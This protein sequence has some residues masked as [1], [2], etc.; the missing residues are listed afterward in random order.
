[1]VSIQLLIILV[2]I[3]LIFPHSWPRLFT[4]LSQIINFIS[5]SFLDVH[6]TSVNV[7]NFQ[8]SLS[9]NNNNLINEL[10]IQPF[11]TQK[12]I[13]LTNRDYL[14]KPS[15]DDQFTSFNSQLNDF[16]AMA[17]NNV[18]NGYYGHG[19]NQESSGFG[20]ISRSSSILRFTSVMPTP[21]SSPVTALNLNSSEDERQNSMFNCYEF[22]DVYLGY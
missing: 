9:V 20:S 17:S 8:S 12:T 19:S 11:Q 14:M 22:P 7:D 1:M 4:I 21:E 16:N 3:F 10:S 15:V 2:L 6:P 13:N 18:N 5:S